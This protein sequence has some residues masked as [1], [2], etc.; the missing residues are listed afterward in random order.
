[1]VE[2]VNELSCGPASLLGAVGTNLTGVAKGRAEADLVWYNA[3]K[4]C[5]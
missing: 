1:M 4:E 3:V 5:G 2:G